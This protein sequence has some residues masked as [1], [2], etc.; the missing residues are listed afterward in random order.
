MKEGNGLNMKGKEVRSSFLEFFVSKGHTLV[1][2]SALVPLNDPTLLFTNAGMVQFKDVFT[3]V[4]K[5]DYRRATSSQKCVRAG[6]K[7]NDLENVGHTARH[8]TFFEMLGNFS[9]GDYFKSDAIAF[10]WEWVTKDLGL[11]LDHLAVTIFEGEGNIPADEEA[12]GFWKAQ[13][14][15][16]S[17]ILRFG[18]KD[19]FWAMG[20]TGPCGPCSEI[21]YFQGGDLPCAEEAVGKKC[22]GVGCDC[23]RW[24]EIWNLVFMQFERGK[25]GVMKPLPRPSIDTGAGLERISAIMQGKRNNY[26]SDLFLGLLSEGARIAGVKYGA[27]ADSDVSLRVMADHA[28]TTAFLV[29]DGVIPSNEGRGYV[30][31]RI[32]RRAIRHGFKLEIK[33]LF[34]DKLCEVVIDEMGD[35]YPEIPAHAALIKK[36]AQSEEE[37]FRQTLAQGCR[38]LD[39]EFEKMAAG[40]SKIVSGEATFKLHDTYGFP[41][42]LTETIAAEKGFRVDLEGYERLMEDQRNRS[43]WKGSGD[44]AQDAFKWKRAQANAPH[45]TIFKGYETEVVPSTVIRMI[46]VPGK[47][48]VSEAKACESVEI[49]V[50]ETP[51][52]AESG[53]QIGDKGFIEGP[54]GQFKVRIDDVKKVGDHFFHIGVVE[55]GVVRVGTPPDFG[56]RGLPKDLNEIDKARGAEIEYVSVRVD[57]NRRA[58]IKAAHSATH[59]L[60]GALRKVLGE[61]VKQAGSLVDAD[62]TR[63]DFHHFSPMTPEQIAAVEDE[64][65]AR[66]TQNVERKYH[67]DLPMDEAVKRGAI[68]LFGEKYGEKVR[69]VEIGESKE[70]CGGTHVDRTGDI[71]FFKIVSEGSVA[72]GVR[73]V[74]AYTGRKAEAHVRAG[75]AVLWAAAERLKCA[76]D[77]VAAR[78]GSLHERL[79][80]LE[81]QIEA[82]KDR[83]SAAESK[84]SADA[85]R[86]VGGIKA[87]A[88]SIENAD[89]A[90]LR[91]HAD[92]LKEQLKSGVVLVGTVRDGKASFVCGVTEDLTKRFHAGKIVGAVA[93]IVGGKGGGRPDMAQAG[94]PDASKLKEALEMFYEVVRS[95]GSEK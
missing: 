32:M 35:V 64:V 56:V 48:D 14:V 73:R 43:D 58:R 70:L 81:R 39:E 77:E 68:A 34:L 18:S 55:S 79:R 13:G 47:G 31:R 50:D 54:S 17:R 36:V 65:N 87:I 53:G 95:Q 89:P 19:N 2:S 11:P 40:K 1:R 94:G 62:Y 24:V 57:P 3:G 72:A 88:T 74:E 22:L 10:A 12:A 84:K 26:D 92:K 37:G 49:V 15:P 5:R 9:F 8:H 85:A 78:V 33:D 59:L 7:H 75:E 67:A 66:I 45:G 80:E 23:D 21:H 28:R 71:G 93:A 90:M 20:E 6:G 52:Y 41:T 63:F 25:D 42:D 29:A 30:L 61:H 86:E 91:G 69:M 46:Y 51:C 82:F 4:E 76:P 83:I 27:A 38:L 16:E 60:H 44:K